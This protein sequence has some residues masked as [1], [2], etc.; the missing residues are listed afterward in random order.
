M[1]PI[2]GFKRRKK[3]SDH[4]VDQNASPSKDHGASV[5]SPTDKAVD[6][7]DDFSK[8]ITGTPCI[9]LFPFDF[10]YLDEPNYCFVFAPFN[11]RTRLIVLA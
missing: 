6:W 10:I 1:G 8:R 5:P 4:K 3:S 7:W 2:R 11:G 9:P